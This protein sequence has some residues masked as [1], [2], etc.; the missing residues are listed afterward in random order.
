MRAIR[1]L[2]ILFVVLLVYSCQETNPVVPDAYTING[3]VTFVDSNFTLGGAGQYTVYAWR[4]ENWNPLAGNPA[5]E[6][7]VNI[8]KENN[9]YVMSY[10]YRLAEV[11]SGTYVAALMYTDGLSFFKT[12]GVYSC[13]IPPT[14]TACYLSPNKY[15][16]IRTTEGLID[17]DITAYGDTA[18]AY[19]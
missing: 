13:T 6:Q 11:P 10:Q 9:Q 4:K 17:I 5:S 1:Y 14:D 15:A 18:N 8:V 7:V 12:L 2:I 3:R 19:P 16:T